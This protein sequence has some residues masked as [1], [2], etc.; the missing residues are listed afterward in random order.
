MN[1]KRYRWLLYII[2]CT[3]VATIAVQIYWN[4]KNYQQNNQHVQNELQ[5]SL[6]NAIETYFSEVA[7]NDF[8]TLIDTEIQTIDTTHVH[9]FKKGIKGEIVNWNL[10]NKDSIIIHSNKGGNIKFRSSSRFSEIDLFKKN[11]LSDSLNIINNIKSIYLSIS[12][13]SINYSKLDSLV[14]EQLKIK[15]ID[16]I[17]KG[18]IHSKDG[19]NIYDNALNF[20]V[21][22]GL[23]SREKNKK[24]VFKFDEGQTDS[25]SKDNVKFELRGINS[26]STFL[27]NNE[28]LKLIYGDTSYEALKRSSTGILLSLLLSLA[29]ISSLFYLLKIIKNQKQ[30]AEIKNDLISN[31][32]HEFKTP[33]TTVSTALEAIHNFNAIDDKEKTK[34]YLDISSLQLKKLHQMVEKLLETATLDSAKLLLQKEAI[35]VVSLVKNTSQKEEFLS[36]EKNIEF[37]S[38]KEEFIINLDPFHFENAIS[39]LIDNAIKYGGNTIEVHLNVVLNNVEITIADSGNDIEKNQ[40]EKIFEQFYRI[41]KGNTHNVKGFGIGL[42][43]TKKIIEKHGGS[44]VLVPNSSNTT[45]KISLPI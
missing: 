19:A 26:K 38:F 40:R 32:T 44:I 27:R 42:Y 37:N 3:V 12:N 7:K 20:G 5:A 39:N 14:K 17:Y 29:I 13:D 31:I 43:Y 6:D 16:V 30:L 24:I 15:N 18:L 2:T 33:I 11:K 22:R 45:F 10:N 23:E 41:P 21:T 1:T 9:N 35:D 25:I 28:Q 8:L 34:K 4:Y 36:S